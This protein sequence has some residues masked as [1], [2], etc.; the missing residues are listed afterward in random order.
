MRLWILLPALL[1]CGS[2]LGNVAAAATWKIHYP[3]TNETMDAHTAYPLQVLALALEQTTVRYDL[4]PTKKITLQ[5]RAIELLKANREVNII[6]SMT[7]SLREEEL[8]PVRIPIYKGLIGLRL[9]LVN[10]EYL[11]LIAPVQ[12]LQE[13]R[14]FI[15]VQGFDWPDTKILQANGFEVATASDHKQIHKMLSADN[16]NFFP[17][18]IIEVWGEMKKPQ[19]PSNLYLEKRLALH[20]PTATYFF[21]NKKDLVLA[22]L[23]R[24]GLERAIANGKFDDLFMSE[25][26]THLQNAHLNERII[27]ELDN[28]V[29]PAATPL[30]R[31]ELWFKPKSLFPQKG[32]QVGASSSKRQHGNRNDR[33]GNS[34]KEM[35]IKEIDSKDSE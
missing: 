23:V 32:L 19:F 31:K 13:L 6:W 22:N 10:L 7:D 2:F 14:R 25:H 29:L 20:Y 28:P 5:G 34:Q 24:T 18:S 21:F 17:R 8:L 4:I 27:F 12:Q 33:R 9:F 3:R 16:A 11:E 30:D 35:D 26:K 1:F 15:P